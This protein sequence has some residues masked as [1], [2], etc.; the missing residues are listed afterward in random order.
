MDLLAKMAT[1]V[2]VVE[3]GSFSAAAKQLRISSA[4]VSRQIAALEGD[5]E[6]SLITRSTRRMAITPRRWACS[7]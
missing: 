3:S 7:R 1:Y 6:A 2:R 5:L 4:A